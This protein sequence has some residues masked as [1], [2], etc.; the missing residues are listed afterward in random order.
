MPKKEFSIKNLLNTE[1]LFGI[2]TDTNEENL[3]RAKLKIFYISVHDLVS[4]RK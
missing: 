2:E 3:S 4:V 1:S